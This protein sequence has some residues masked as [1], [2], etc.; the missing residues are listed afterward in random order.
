MFGVLDTWLI[1]RWWH[2]SMV[3]WHFDWWSFSIDYII[4][5]KT[6]GG[7]LFPAPCSIDTDTEKN[8][9]IINKK[10]QP[11]PEGDID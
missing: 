3:Y 2:I 10:Q 6:D 4:G 1:D 11:Q 9:E 5:T 7:A 8:K